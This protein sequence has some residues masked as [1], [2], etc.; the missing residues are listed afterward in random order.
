M[1]STRPPRERE[2]EEVIKS[3]RRQIQHSLEPRVA[4]EDPWGLAEVIAL[5]NELDAVAIRTVKRLRTA[6]YTWS[7]IGYSLG[8]SADRALQRYSHKIENLP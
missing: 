7:A 6:G 5:R 1:T 2:T 3:I 8:V 4:E